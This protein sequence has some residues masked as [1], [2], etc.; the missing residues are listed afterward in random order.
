MLNFNSTH[1]GLTKFLDIY[2]K[3]KTYEFY[4]ITEQTENQVRVNDATDFL[5]TQK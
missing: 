2:V 5:F 4:C 1:G 3:P